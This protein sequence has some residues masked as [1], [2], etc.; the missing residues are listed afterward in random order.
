MANELRNLVKQER[1]SLKTFEAVECFL[2]NFDS[3]VHSVEVEIRLER[4]EAAF[5]EF[6]RVRRQIELITEDVEEDEESEMEKTL[7]ETS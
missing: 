1:N 2:D 5:S 4:L 6:H 7:S 3:S